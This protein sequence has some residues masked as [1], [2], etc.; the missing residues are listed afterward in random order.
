[1]A[2]FA[3]DDYTVA[4]KPP[5]FV[6]CIMVSNLC[7]D[8]SFCV[9]FRDLF[10]E[11]NRLRPIMKIMSAVFDHAVNFYLKR[12]SHCEYPSLCRFDKANI[13]TIDRR[14]KRYY[15]FFLKN[16][17]VMSK[18]A[19]ETVAQSEKRRGIRS[20]SVKLDPEER[21]LWDRM[22]ERHGGRKASLISALRLLEGQNR[23]TNEELIAELRQR[24]GG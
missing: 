4:V 20:T 1:M 23:L 21:A 14:V 2:V 19:S 7:R 12:A 16:G 15:R 8:T 6:R 10:G 13:A 18:S 24:L 17:A 11:L 5:A 9:G 3:A 22:S